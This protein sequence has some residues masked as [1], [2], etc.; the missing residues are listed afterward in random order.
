MISFV[1]PNHSQFKVYPDRVVGP[2]RTFEGM[3]SVVNGWPAL[4]KPG[5]LKRLDVLEAI[6]LIEVADNNRLLIHFDHEIDG[7][8]YLCFSQAIHLLANF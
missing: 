4:V 7:M 2:Y 8:S 1:H 6:T 5:F 3:E